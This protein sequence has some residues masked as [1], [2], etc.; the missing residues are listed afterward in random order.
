EN[1][2]FGFE[3]AGNEKSRWR[4]SKITEEFQRSDA[5]FVVSERAKQSLVAFGVDA[6]KVFSHRYCVDLDSFPCRKTP[7][8]LGKKLNVIFVGASIPR[9]GV[10]RLIEA[11]L[12]YGKD[13]IKLTFV[14]NRATDAELIK[15]IDSAVAAGLEMDLVGSVPQS[16]LKNYYWRADVFCLPSL[17]DGWGMVTNQAAA[18]GLP[19]LVSNY[20]G[21]SDLV[22][23]GE[24][25]YTFDPRDVSQLVEALTK[26]HQ[27][28]R[29]DQRRMSRSSRQAAEQFGHWQRHAEDVKDN[30]DRVVKLKSRPIG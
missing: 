26:M 12:R 11:A 14:G 21:S 7:P 2:T 30:I 23:E 1:I 9:K 13:K 17:V 16:I 20:A 18:C 29:T 19:L 28:S 4:E 25:G 15:S 8:Q 22:K 3:K 24:N 6:S 27:L 5:I 10:H